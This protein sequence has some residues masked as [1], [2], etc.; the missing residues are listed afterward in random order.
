[1][2]RQQQH[3]VST[4]RSEHAEARDM[5][6]QQQGWEGTE[7]PLLLLSTAASRKRSSQHAERGKSIYLIVGTRRVLE[8]CRVAR[9]LS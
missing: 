9:E 8:T 5:N 6:T 4:T 2:I 7:F 3:T 1:M